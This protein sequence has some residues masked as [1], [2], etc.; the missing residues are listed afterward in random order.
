MRYI[1]CII[2]LCLISSCKH[3]SQTTLK[4]EASDKSSQDSFRLINFENAAFLKSKRFL[5]EVFQM[6]MSAF[7]FLQLM[8]KILK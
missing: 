6:A 2:S 3:S 8:E 7:S 5:N 4:T 1:A